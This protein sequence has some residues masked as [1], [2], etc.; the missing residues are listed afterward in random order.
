MAVSNSAVRWGKTHHKQ[1]PLS[2][3][4]RRYGVLRLVYPARH[5]DGSVEGRVQDG[6]GR[7]QFRHVPSLLSL[8]PGWPHDRCAGTSD[9]GAGLE[10]FLACHLR[11]A[12]AECGKTS[13]WR[14]APAISPGA[15][16]YG[17][18]L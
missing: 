7:I 18:C 10:C 3:L 1:E 4:G 2:A 9:T 8:C 17:R 14:A 5:S 13:S 15:S 16:E 12:A 6:G 11:K